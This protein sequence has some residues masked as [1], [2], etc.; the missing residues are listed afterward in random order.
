M[1]ARLA[2]ICVTLLRE[3]MCMMCELETRIAWCKKGD[4]AVF[5][6]CTIN[7]ESLTCSHG[8]IVFEATSRARVL[9]YVL[10]TFW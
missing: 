10:N 4:V 7:F 9:K 8:T 3:C 2:F 5:P 1:R 6:Y